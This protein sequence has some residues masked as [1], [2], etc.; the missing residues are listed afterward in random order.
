MASTATVPRRRRSGSSRSWFQ[1]H[2]RFPLAGF[3][4]ADEPGGF[5]LCLEV[6][7]CPVH[8]G[9]GDTHDHADPA[10]EGAEHL[11][12][13]DH[14]H[15]LQ[16][17]EDYRAL[18]RTGI[19]SGAGARR[20]HARQILGQSTPRDVGEGA[21]PVPLEQ[22]LWPEVQQEESRAEGLVWQLQPGF[23]A[24]PVSAFP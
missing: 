16:P 22:R 17:V 4:A 19:D 21:D 11:A 15:A 13:I 5:A 14:P 12:A 8:I 10:I 9:R 18:P 7:Q 2:G 1:D 23:S 3:D 24:P 6:F 20:H